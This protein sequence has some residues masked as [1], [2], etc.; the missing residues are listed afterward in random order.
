MEWLTNLFGWLASPWTSLSVGTRR[1]VLFV[2][3]HVLFVLLCVIILAVVNHLA[4]LDRL[5]R[6]QWLGVNRAWLPLLFLLLYSLGW[7]VWGL[8]LLLGPDREPG[9]FADVRDAWS[10]A[11][12]QLDA[13]GIPL[14]Q[15]PVFLVLGRPASDLETVFA[16]ARVPLQVR[17]VPPRPDAPLRVFA[18]R[19]AVYVCCPGTGLL[20]LHTDRL[21]ADVPSETPEV[22]D[23]L[24]EAPPPS[25]ELGTV[26]SQA[27]VL[28]LTETETATVARP[29]R[30]SLLRDEATVDEQTRR[31]RHVCRLLV[32]DRQPLCP[33][34]G[35]IVLLPFEAT[36]GADEATEAAAV[37]RHDLAVARAALQLD[38][39][40]FVV[41]C[42]AQR[43]SGFTRLAGQFPEGSGPA[44]L[45]GQTF[46][47]APDVPPAEVPAVIESGLRWVADTMLPLVLGRM[48]RREG[49]GGEAEDRTMVVRGNVEL[50]RY[51]IAMRERVYR[52]ARLTALGLTPEGTQPPLLAGCYLA[53]TGRDEREQAFLAGVVRRALEQQNAVRWSAEA[54]AEDRAYHG[55]TVA[56]YV[57]LIAFL[58][59]VAAVLWSW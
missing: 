13:A 25:L 46:P 15:V 27:A 2:I 53:G 23:L 9:E 10:E 22:A 36:D 44:R 58:A 51:L 38:C 3:G 29:R 59:A 1:N 32:R 12:G 52:L 43:Q 26:H 37:M 18:G 30:A 34:N 19:D 42:D 57:A 45:L 47:L 6:T 55:Y 7:L 54:L 40:R 33:V 16:A 8:W 14:G 20:P 39:P 35:V 28:L 49:E 5:V 4:G 31:L 24:S 11:R 17:G 41:L 56:G 50:Y 21:L 48:I